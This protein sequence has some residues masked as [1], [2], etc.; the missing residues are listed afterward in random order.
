MSH[1]HAQAAYLGSV[2][3]SKSTM[4]PQKIGSLKGVGL[5]VLWGHV[6]TLYRVKALRN[7]L[8]GRV[9]ILSYI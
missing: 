4:G 1:R 5:R 6:E 8:C 2:R 7:A 9:P 3:E